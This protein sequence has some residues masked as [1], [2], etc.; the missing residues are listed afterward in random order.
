MIS[1]IGLH[2]L[3]AKPIPTPV[4]AASLIGVEMT[5][6]STGSCATV[7]FRRR[8]QHGYELSA[9]ADSLELVS[10]GTGLPQSI[11]R[12]PSTALQPGTRHLVSIAVD[13]HHAAVS[14]DGILALQAALDDPSLASGGVAL[15]VT[16]SS[17]GASVLFANLDVR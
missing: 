17:G 2:S 16:G 12:V 10:A 9:C 3:M 4:M 6:S 11:G 13:D 15:G 7:W 8:D 1:T 5:L 14:I